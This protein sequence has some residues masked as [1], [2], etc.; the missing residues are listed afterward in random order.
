VPS[1]VD[2]GYLQWQSVFELAGLC[3]KFRKVMFGLS[4]M[5]FSKL[6]LTAYKA[7]KVKTGA[8]GMSANKG[9]VALQ[10]KLD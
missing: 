2:V 5:V 7:F 1:N 10:F 9:A 8:N 4:I 6:K 3:L